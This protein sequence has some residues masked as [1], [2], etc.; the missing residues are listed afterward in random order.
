MCEWCIIDSSLDI[1]ADDDDDDEGC[2]PVSP[3]RPPSSF[4][5]A[6]ASAAAAAPLP[7]V[8]PFASSLADEEEDEDDEEAVGER[9][10]PYSVAWRRC[11][12]EYKRAHSSF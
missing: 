11:R 6:S 1:P 10:R 8:P 5:Y 12:V 7:L 9:G 2:E 3:L 4:A